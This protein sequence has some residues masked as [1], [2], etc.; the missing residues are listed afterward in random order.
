MAERK[1]LIRKHLA[2]R[3]A[4]SWKILLALRPEHASTQVYS[5]ASDNWTTQDV[6][7]HLADSEIGLQLQ[8]RRL[9]NGDDAVPPDFDLARWNR[10]AV[11]RRAESSLDELRS[12]VLQAHKQ[13]IEL[14]DEFEEDV[15]DMRGLVSTGEVLSVQELLHRIGDHRLEH[16]NDI[17]R[18]IEGEA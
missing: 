14:L 11:S 9:V 4:E 6:M 12:Q 10:A 15:L 2:S 17:R 16:A 13:A 7:A 3:H 8:V 1:D 18:A 5:H